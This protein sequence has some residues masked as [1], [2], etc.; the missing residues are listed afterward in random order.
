MIFS[1]FYLKWG[2]QKINSKLMSLDKME[3]V[4]EILKAIAHP[5]RLCIIKGLIEDKESNDKNIQNCLNVPQSTISQHLYKL[6]TA[7]IVDYRKD[8][9][10]SNYYIVNSDVV[11]IV[12]ILFEA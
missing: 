3:D 2:V 8:G 9:V 5:I 10:E 12:G 6:R 7:G 4:S 11:K 1:L